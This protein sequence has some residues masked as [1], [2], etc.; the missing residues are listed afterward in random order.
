MTYQSL[1][2]TSD[3]VQIRLT[4]RRTNSGLCEVVPMSLQQH[5]ARLPLLVATMLRCLWWL[6]AGPRRTNRSPYGS[7]SCRSRDGKVH[8]RADC[9]DH[10]QTWT[11]VCSTGAIT[12]SIAEVVAC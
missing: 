5:P 6:R 10:G 4:A 12:G 1:I 9:Y 11:A 7:L 3:D 2:N 8:V